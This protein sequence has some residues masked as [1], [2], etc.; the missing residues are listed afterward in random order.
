MTKIWASDLERSRMCSPYKLLNGTASSETL[1]SNDAL[2]LL[3]LMLLGVAL[4]GFAG[5]ELSL[6][7]L[8]C[9]EEIGMAAVAVACAMLMDAVGADMQLERVQLE[10]IPLATVLFGNAIRYRQIW[11]RLFTAMKGL[12]RRNLLIRVLVL[13]CPQGFTIS[14]LQE[15]LEDVALCASQEAR[16]AVLLGTHERVGADSIFR[17]IPQEILEVILGKCAPKLPCRVQVLN[18]TSVEPPSFYGEDLDCIMGW[19]QS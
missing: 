10:I 6:K 4:P 5:T 15:D 1:T 9:G 11:A 7:V 16:M 2:T 13:N 19:M 17:G 18:G 14:R 3:D 8:V 12:L